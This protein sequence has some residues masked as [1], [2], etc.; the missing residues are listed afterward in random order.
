[1]R[2]LFVIAIYCT[3]LFLKIPRLAELKIWISSALLQTTGS[4]NSNLY[5]GHQEFLKR[6]SVVIFYVVREFTVPWCHFLGH[7]C[8]LIV[9]QWFNQLF[10]W[11]DSVYPW[12]LDQ[13]FQGQVI[14]VWHWWTCHATSRDKRVH[15]IQK[16]PHTKYI[17]ITFLKDNW[18]CLN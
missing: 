7:F 9:T 6:E 8:Q 10:D 17:S 13:T 11:S 3:H 1:M 14:C 18:D 12:H 2:I 4:Q 16:L 5:I 15:Y